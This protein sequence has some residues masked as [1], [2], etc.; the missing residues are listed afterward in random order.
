[1]TDRYE[2]PLASRYASDYMLHLF[3]ADSRYQTWRKLWTELAREERCLGLPITEEQ[4]AAIL[5]EVLISVALI[6]RIY[7]EI[8]SEISLAV[9]TGVVEHPTDP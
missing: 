2:S 5:S 4:V 7:S 8:Y 9:A 6:L 3:S 1:M